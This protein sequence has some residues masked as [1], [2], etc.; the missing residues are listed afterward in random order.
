MRP[1]C[2]PATST[3]M[4]R[5]PSRVWGTSRVSS[6]D[7]RSQS[8]YRDVTVGITAKLYSGGGEGID[9]S[10]VGPPQGSLPAGGPLR[11]ERMRFQKPITT[12]T[13]WMYAPMELMRLKIS[14]P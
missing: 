13:T 7:L 3:L 2:L 6:G 8:G 12:A 11:R 9:H 4:A 14:S 1:T 5:S 10:S